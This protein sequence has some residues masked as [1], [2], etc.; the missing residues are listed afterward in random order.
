MRPPALLVTPKRRSVKAVND[1]LNRSTILSSVQIADD[2]I[3][4]R[5]I[6]MWGPL[7]NGCGSGRRLSGHL[8]DPAMHGNPFLSGQRKAAA[9]RRFATATRQLSERAAAIKDAFAT[10]TTGAGVDWVGLRSAISRVDK[11]VFIAHRGTELR[12]LI[13][14]CTDDDHALTSIL[15]IVNKW[16]DAEAS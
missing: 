14:T 12:V 11:Q 6:V 13:E 1:T 5:S 16:E 9:R 8:I 2:G 7:E 4:G 15:Q 3:G 10:H